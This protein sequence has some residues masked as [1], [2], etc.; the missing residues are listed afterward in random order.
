M[1][2]QTRGWDR[3][4]GWRELSR[5]SLKTARE[6]SSGWQIGRDEVVIEASDVPANRRGGGKA[7]IYFRAEV[8]NPAL[9]GNYMVGITLNKFD[10]A[11]L[12]KTM[13]AGCPAEYVFQLLNEVDPG[14]DQDE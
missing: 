1:I 13:I 2:L 6:V 7:K 14:A 10:I 5:H 12:F 8:Q 9:N 4:H 3:N 11:R